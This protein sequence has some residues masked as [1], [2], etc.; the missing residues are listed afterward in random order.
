MSEH[1]SSGSSLDDDHRG[2]PKSPSRSQNRNRRLIPS[3]GLAP[4]HDAETQNAIRRRIAE[5]LPRSKRPYDPNM[6]E[7]VLPADFMY[8]SASPT[9]P[10]TPDLASSST[11]LEWNGHTQ[12]Q[13]SMHGTLPVMLDSSSANSS[14]SSPD[15]SS[16]PDIHV[17]GPVPIS[18]VTILGAGRVDPFAN[19]P[20]KMNR[21]ELWLID[22]VNM[23]QDP[24]FRTHRERW[25]PVMIKSPI[26]FRQFLA[27]VSL[28]ISRVR[29]ENLDNVVTVAHHSLAI[30]LVNQK[31]SDPVSKTSDEVLLGILSFRCYN[32]VKG[33]FEAAAVHLEGLK[34]VL[35]LRRGANRTWLSPV[36]SNLMYS[37]EMTRICR[38]DTKVV[39]PFPMMFDVAQEQQF[40]TT[41]APHPYV[42][43][44]SPWQ[45]IFPADHPI[46][47]TFDSLSSA[48]R[49]AGHKFS[50]DQSWKVVNY[51]VHSLCPIVHQ[52]MG[53][54]TDGI[55]N[56]YW[57]I[58]QEAS[59]LS[60]FFFLGELRR[61]CGA[62]GVSNTLFLSKF[63][64]HM[65]NFGA[66][67]DWR[68]CH[69]LLLWMLF[70]GT[71]ES[72]GFS[73]QGWF[74][75]TIVSVAKAMNLTSWDAIVDAVKGFLWVE[76]VYD[77]KAAI[78]GQSLMAEFS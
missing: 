24:T 19:Y 3:P 58:V 16:K 52:L 35:E 76:D 68:P 37:V 23:D 14:S 48:V 21:G 11:R 31:L 78:V 60:I 55:P 12:L 45:T 62:L 51:V 22:Q 71:L 5:G 56:D 44:N 1:S 9:G 2:A 17:S 29:G 69:P 50:H 72:W 46:I 74:L 66:S 38:Q 75:E 10:S 25:L 53:L 7:L 54:K 65:S 42:T 59:R 67:I 43:P 32:L 61:Q 6:I 28:N 34:K 27:N 40:G 49:V 36:L 57:T 8:N 39:F 70:F 64:C 15:M 73:E 47:D 26:T 77:A 63:K 41:P 4:V 33:D 30:R 13:G 20:I 18:P